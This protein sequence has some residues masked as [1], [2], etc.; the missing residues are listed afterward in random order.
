MKCMYVM[1][2]ALCLSI[3]FTHAN[4]L[5]ITQNQCPSSCL[6]PLGVTIVSAGVTFALKKIQQKNPNGLGL[7]GLI[8][9][10]T[11]TTCMSTLLTYAC[12]SCNN[13]RN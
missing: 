12:Y 8:I 10:S 4:P 9:H 1:I 7:P 2:A 3:P 13:A 11:T 6:L 5:E